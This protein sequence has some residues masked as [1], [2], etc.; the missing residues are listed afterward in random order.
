M[1]SLGSHQGGGTGSPIACVLG[2]PFFCHTCP[3]PFTP[4]MQT[5]PWKD[6]PVG[7]PFST[8]SGRE[9]SPWGLRF[10]FLHKQ[11]FV[12]RWKLSYLSW[13]SSAKSESLKSWE[14]WPQGQ[15][16]FSKYLYWLNQLFLLP[17]SITWGETYPFR[18]VAEYQEGLCPEVWAFKSSEKRQKITSKRIFFPL[19][20]HIILYFESP[21]I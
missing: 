6:K 15:K 5:F 7:W 2:S 9:K 21:C 17:L 12:L 3:R 4:Q 18:V 11:E 16:T 10:L 8:E 19:G 13:K 1:A 20:F 14:V